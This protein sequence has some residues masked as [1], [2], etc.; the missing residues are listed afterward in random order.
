MYI[1]PDA[2]HVLKLYYGMMQLQRK[3]KIEKFFGG[4]NRKEKKP[5]YL[6]MKND[7]TFCNLKFMQE[8]QFIAPAALHDE[9]LRLRND[10]QMDFLESLTGMDWE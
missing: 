5:D 3:V 7:S 4:V 1:F 2:R 9:T 10:K 8:I 6:K